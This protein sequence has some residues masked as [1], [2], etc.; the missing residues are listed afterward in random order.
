MALV[1]NFFTV[2]VATLGSRVMGF[3]RDVLMAATM[4]TGPVADAFVVAFRLPN[5]FR[6]LFA[7][8]AFNSAFVPLFAKKLGNDGKRDARQFAEDALAVLFWT[9]AILTGIAMIFMPALVYVMAPGFVSQPEKFEDAVLF[10]QI[11]FPYLACMSLIAL[12][13][14]VLN[15]VGRFAAAA[16]AP[17]LM[18]FVLV[19]GLLAAGAWGY[20]GTRETGIVVSISVALAG[21]A[22]L[23]LLVVATERAGWTLTLRA[24]RLTPE[25]KRM[26]ALAVPG[27]IA[28]GVQQINL[29]VGTII[30]SSAPAAISWLYYADR[31][32]QLPLGIVGIAIGVVLLPEIARQLREGDARVGHTQNRA[33]EL[34]M[35]L[36]LPAATALALVPHA[37]IGGLFER[38]AF[39][40]NDTHAVAIALA[41]FAAGLPGFVLTKVFSPGFFA[42]EDTTWPMIFAVISVAVNV[43]FSLALFPLIGH[44]GIAIATSIAGWVNALL[45]WLVLWRR[46]HFAW[47]RLLT[48]RLGAILIASAVMGAA[49][50]ALNAV[51]AP[52][53]AASQSFLIKVAALGVLC[54]GGLAVYAI[55]LVLLGGADHM[56]L[57]EAFRRRKGAAPVVDSA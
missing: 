43:A 29:V 12:F 52:Y 47:D 54:G 41:A 35:M 6:R 55:V 50:L 9:L 53:L 38:G 42:R 26:F 16:W 34:A 25:V 1:R 3:V 10:S 56:A 19:L 31:L 45:L 49:L 33:F 17:L 13:A 48:R 8:G 57:K 5:L 32:Y 23:A 21:I 4:G 39:T 36:T 22:Q 30:A 46:G 27:V 28:G 11:C 20:I 37:I 2:G 24:P 51:A 44:V 40:A 18:N 14:G 15:S 7:E